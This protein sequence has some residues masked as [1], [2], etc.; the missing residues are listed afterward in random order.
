MDPG[1]PEALKTPISPLIS[2]HI[3]SVTPTSVPIV[4][5]LI[6]SIPGS[7]IFGEPNTKV[8]V[9]DNGNTLLLPPVTLDNTG[10]SNSTIDFSQLS[11][12]TILIRDI[13]NN[14]SS[15]PILVDQ[16]L[17]ITPQ[18]GPQKPFNGGTKFD[19]VGTPNEQVEISIFERNVNI[20]VTTITPTIS[21]SGLIHVQFPQPLKL[22]P[23]D[24][25]LVKNVTNN[26]AS[27]M[28][29][30]D[31]VLDFN[32]SSIPVENL[33][34]GFRINSTVFKRLVNGVTIPTEEFKE[35]FQPC[36][37]FPENLSFL[38]SITDNG[39]GRELQS[40]PI[41]NIAG[42][43]IANGDR[44]FRPFPKPLVFEPR[45]V[46]LF[47]VQEISGGPGTLYFVLQGYKVLGTGALRMEE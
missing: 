6:S 28:Q 18:F 21:P 24:T 36:G 46:I 29:I 9:L 37:V 23:G 12:H 8:I 41:H 10:Q 3:T 13:T 15:P 47:Q 11:G 17:L 1:D 22:K 19:I 38:Y 14:T 42:L 44:P 45:S 16:N 25:V 34:Q 4:P 27:V 26:Y 30:P 39:T 5:D 35:P 20:P 33:R 40:E 32:L 7:T 2:P 43:G 31:N